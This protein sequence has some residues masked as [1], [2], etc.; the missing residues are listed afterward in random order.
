MDDHLGRSSHSSL[1]E[2]PLEYWISPDLARPSDPEARSRLRELADTR[3]AVTAARERRSGP[4]RFSFS[5]GSSSPSWAEASD[6]RP[7][8][9][10]SERD[11]WFSMLGCRRLRSRL[12]NT[13]RTLITRGPGSTRGGI[14]MIAFFAV[15]P[16]AVFGY[17]VFG[18]GARGGS[19]RT[20]P[21]DVARS[22][23][24]CHVRASL[25]AARPQAGIVDRKCHVRVEETK[26]CDVEEMDRPG[27]DRR[28][29]TGYVERRR[30][31]P[32]TT[33]S[34]LQ[35]LRGATRKVSMLIASRT[36]H[37]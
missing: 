14:S 22:C 4:A 31:L 9:E 1:P 36:L 37:T 17:S 6:L 12:P 23:R 33:V 11:S 3:G 13:R 7:P 8:S 29:T 16:G 24:R 19:P 35:T 15:V 32:T 10:S 30:S 18:N 28:V 2:R 21:P 25:T 34:W 5:P 27:S 26:R 20:G